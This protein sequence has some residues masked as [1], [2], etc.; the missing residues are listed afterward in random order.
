MTANL[1]TGIGQGDG[2]DSIA[3]V[4][5]LTGSPQDDGLTGNTADNVLDGAGGQDAVLFTSATDAD[6]SDLVLPNASSATDGNDALV[7]IEDLRGSSAV[8]NLDGD[9]GP[10]DIRGIG[11]NDIVRGAGGDDNL[12]GNAGEDEVNG[13]DDADTITGGDDADQLNGEAGTDGVEGGNGGDD[14]SGGS[15]ADVLTGDQ[16]DDVLVGGPTSDE[17]D[18]A[19][20]SS[21]PG[22]VTTGVQGT[23]TDDGNGDTDS[24][25]NIDNLI[26]SSFTDILEGDPDENEFTPGNGDDHVDGNGGTDRVRYDTPGAA[27]NVELDLGGGTGTASGRG[28]D[29]LTDIENATGSPGD[30][31]LA[32]GAGANTLD[33][34][35]GADFL[36]GRGGNDNLFGDAGT[37]TATYS[38]ATGGVTASLN[39]GGT[40]V[41]GDGDGGT[42][43]FSSIQV[44]EGSGNADDLQGQNGG[45]GDLIRSLG[46]QDLVRVRDGVT[47]DTVDCGSQVDRVIMDATE[48]PITNCETQDTPAKPATPTINGSNPGSGANDNSPEIT[49]TALAGSTVRLYT[50][51]DCSGTPVA[52]GSAATFSGAGLTVNVADDSTTTLRASVDTPL[53]LESPSACS[54]GF[55]Y[56]EKTTPDA[57]DPG[58]GGDGGGDGGG[59]E[60]ADTTPPD[61]EIAK[62]IKKTKDTTPTYNFSSSETNSTFECAVDKSDFASCKSPTTL[63]K[64]KK[65]K[66]TFFVQATDSA[67]NTDGTPAEDKFEVKKKRKKK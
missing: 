58:D 17:G 45:V 31:S 35:G 12:E 25:S 4:E 24:L 2:P 53:D 29:T 14:V 56:V 46:G 38:T 63:K 64:L 23:N 10:N 61:T 54:P 41:A 30:D 15:G 9:D 3:T 13:G 44:L 47:A 8:D 66:H 22:S 32:G 62:L 48:G 51:S 50:T 34:G 6:L 42:D 65:G 55:T 26:G 60:P 37:D 18:T 39:D 7:D 52:T 43:T 36:R 21:A 1:T 19:N 27:V 28:L 59:G 67:G 49:G 16:G 40:A 11:G 20:Y 57:V 33:G 5:N